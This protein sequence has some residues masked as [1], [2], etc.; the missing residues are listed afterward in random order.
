MPKQDLPPILDGARFLE[1]LS[2][3]SIGTALME[4]FQGYD[5]CQPA[6][7]PMQYLL[8]EYYLYPSHY[9]DPVFTL[10][11]PRED[12]AI[13]PWSY[14]S[15]SRSPAT[16]DQSTPNSPYIVPEAVGNA[17]TIVTV[18]DNHH[19]YMA[20]RA[21][22]DMVIAL[23]EHDGTPRA[24]WYVKHRKNAVPKPMF[25]LD[26]VRNLLQHQP[27][28][29]DTGARIELWTPTNTMDRY[30]KEIIG[31]Y[32]LQAGYALSG[33]SLVSY[34]AFLSLDPQIFNRSTDGRISLTE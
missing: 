25:S 6:P 2:P 15:K 29:W 32:Q 34:L 28:R 12:E 13:A 5:Q 31:T 21:T 23:D 10:R 1:T 14:F 8:Q 7:L 4:S 16:T 17:S 22:Q 26:P 18:T 20:T 9:G 11:S 33:L 27:E 24:Y 3:I 30:S 19:Y